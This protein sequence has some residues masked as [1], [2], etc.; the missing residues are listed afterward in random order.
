MKLGCGTESTQWSEARN[1]ALSV[2]E[3]VSHNVFPP[4]QA[5]D[6]FSPVN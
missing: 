5:V 3:T 1:V 2:L 6:L 4:G